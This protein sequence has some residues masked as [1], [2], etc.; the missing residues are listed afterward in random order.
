MT[1]KLGKF[2][3]FFFIHTHNAMPSNGRGGHIY[4]YSRLLGSNKANNASLTLV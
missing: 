4:I 3:G 2:S 1:L